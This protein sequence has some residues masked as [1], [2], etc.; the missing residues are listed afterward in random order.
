MGKGQDEK[1]FNKPCNASDKCKH[2]K[3]GYGKKKRHAIER[4]Q[5]K[6]KPA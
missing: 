5:G 6:V 4:A 3:H 1:G 2:K